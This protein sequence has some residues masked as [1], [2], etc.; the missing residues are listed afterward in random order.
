MAK[1][2]R[3]VNVKGTWYKP[4]DDVP[5]ELLAGG[6]LNAAVVDQEVPEEEP[7]TPPADPNAGN[8]GGRDGDGGGD[9]AVDEAVDVPAGTI[10]E[11][12]AWVG[13]DPARARQALEVELAKGEDHR[14]TLVAA[15]E[16]IVAAS[17]GGT[18]TEE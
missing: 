14:K 7:A 15:L 1:F 9:E 10:A 5:A 18:S 3:H 2:T 11:V 8:H 17:E 13:D 6:R 16:A 4:G 12:E